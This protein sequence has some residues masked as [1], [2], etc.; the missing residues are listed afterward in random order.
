MT[1][2]GTRPPYVHEGLAPAV[3]RLIEQRAES[4]PSNA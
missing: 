1:A 4:R 2:H 3:E